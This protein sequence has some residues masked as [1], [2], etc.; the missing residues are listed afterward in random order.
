MSAHTDAQFS[1]GICPE[2]YE[3]ILTPQLRAMHEAHEART[4]Q[5]R[6]P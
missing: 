5:P 1:H 6:K 4:D 3:T 2:C